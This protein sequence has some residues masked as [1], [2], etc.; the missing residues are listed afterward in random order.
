VWLA[1]TYNKGGIA[2]NIDADELA[3]LRKDADSLMAMCSL[4]AQA[5]ARGRDC[6]KMI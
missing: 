3:A 2:M 1:R 4:L 6:Q 5:T